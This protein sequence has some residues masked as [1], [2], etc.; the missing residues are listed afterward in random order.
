M[1]RNPVKRAF[2]AYQH[3]VRDLREDLSFEDGLKEEPNRI[4]NNWELIYHYKAVSLYYDS[5]DSYLLLMCVKYL[6]AHG[7]DKELCPCKCIRLNPWETR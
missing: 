6:C 4:R 7:C 5:V 1:L 2:S 3:M